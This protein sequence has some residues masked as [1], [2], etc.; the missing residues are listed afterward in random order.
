MDDEC[1]MLALALVGDGRPMALALSTLFFPV[2]PSSKLLFAPAFGPSH[3]A[4]SDTEV[5][6]G[7]HNE[8]PLLQSASLRSSC[9]STYLWLLLLRSNLDKFR[10]L[11]V[12]LHHPLLRH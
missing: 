3:S 11:V 12:V 5:D 2:A 4:I 1:M 7:N 9:H 8:T 6:Q 10:Q